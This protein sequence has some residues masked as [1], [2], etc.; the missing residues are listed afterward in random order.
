MPA[1]SSRSCRSVWQGP[2]L[3]LY[4]APKKVVF[5]IVLKKGQ[6]NTLDTLFPFS[7]VTLANTARIRQAHRIEVELIGIS[8]DT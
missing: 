4:F 8:S 3:D 5:A 2:P 7:Q 1:G 6:D